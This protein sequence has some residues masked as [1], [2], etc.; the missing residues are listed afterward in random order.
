MTT[1]GGGGGAVPFALVRASEAEATLKSI[2]A[3]LLPPVTLT[4]ETTGN[5]AMG[6]RFQ[7]LRS[8]STHHTTLNNRFSMPFGSV[9][10][11]SESDLRRPRERELD[12]RKRAKG[13]E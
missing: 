6:L 3:V 13:I 7:W 10:W 5:P 8:T 12:K 11:E 4:S 9:E 1:L 2:A